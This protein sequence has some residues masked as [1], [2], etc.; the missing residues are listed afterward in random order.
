MPKCSAG[1]LLYRKT[2]SGIELLLVHPG[3]PFWARKD[4]GIWSIPKGEHA[5][6]EDPLAAAKREFAE[7]LGNV[8]P[9]GPY[10]DL[11]RI[12]QPGH[13]TIA[14]F[15]TEGDFD[16]ASLRSNLFEMKWPPKN[17]RMQSFPEIDRAEWFTPEVARDKILVRQ[18]PFID[19]L[20]SHLGFNRRQKRL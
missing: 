14:A 7:E 15:A 6:S 20:C 12:A 11:G 19:Q 8:P 4:Q 3:G 1:I 18:A 2:G 10:F 13:K 16:P 17:G 9:E 5:A